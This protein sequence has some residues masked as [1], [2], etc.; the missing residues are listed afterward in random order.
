MVHYKMLQNNMKDIYSYK[1]GAAAM[2][3]IAMVSVI[4]LGLA[5]SFAFAAESDDDEPI[6]G[7]ADIS[8]SEALRIADEAY[9]G[10]GSRTDIELE[11]EDGVLVYEVEYTESDGNQ[12]DVKLNA[13]T[14]EVVS[15]ESDETED[16]NDDM[17]DAEDENDTEEDNSGIDDTDTSRV[18]DSRLTSTDARVTE[19]MERLINLLQQ[20]LDLLDERA[21]L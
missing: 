8:E 13:D 1:V 15:I 9:T 18:D 20:I 17:D 12:V 14:G 7:T 11:M 5:T 21:S 16:P 6:V 19:R 3:S 10:A 2:A 4:T